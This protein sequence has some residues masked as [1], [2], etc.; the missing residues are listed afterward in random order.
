MVNGNGVSQVKTELLSSFFQ[1]GGRPEGG[2]KVS[3][4]TPLGQDGVTGSNGRISGTANTI[5]LP[6]DPAILFSYT[7]NQDHGHPVYTGYTQIAG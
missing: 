3:I 1:A 2:H 5:Y 6:V 7:T 4:A